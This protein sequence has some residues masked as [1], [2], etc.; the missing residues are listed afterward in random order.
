MKFVKYFFIWLCMFMVL[1]C[2]IGYVYVRLEGEHLFE[3]QFSKFFGQESTVESVRY[4][5]PFGVRFHKLEIRNV[6]EA[7]DVFFH[8]RLPFLLERQFI[9]ARLELVKPIF[10][11][12]RPEQKKLDFGGAYLA[13]QEERFNV[14]KQNIKP[15]DG[16]L[17][18]FL[19]VE[20]GRIEILDL[21]VQEPVKYTIMDIN[22]KAL[23]FAY[24]PGNQNIKFDMEGRVV[25]AGGRQWLAKSRLSATGW[26]NWISRAMEADMDFK[27]LDGVSATMDL[28]SKNNVLEGQ[29]KFKIGSATEGQKEVLTKGRKSGLFLT[30]TVLNILNETQTELALNFNFKTAM[31]AFHLESVN[32]EGTLDLPHEKKVFDVLNPAVLFDLGK[33]GAKGSKQN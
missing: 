27:G 24:P 33:Q 9:I 25:S 28:K 11:L 14:V 18:D 22:G 32:F 20:G 6:L 3:Q 12:V 7:E 1:S 26:V 15:I 23:K 13:Q 19:S 17:I 21:A 30:K 31:D 2:V 8:L 10:Y 16:V 5:V 29:G 4:L